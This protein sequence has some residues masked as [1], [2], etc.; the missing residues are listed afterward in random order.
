MSLSAFGLASCGCALTSL[1]LSTQWFSGPSSSSY[2]SSCPP[3]ST[4][5]SPTRPLVMPTA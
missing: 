3:P 2:T 4:L 1:M 5:S